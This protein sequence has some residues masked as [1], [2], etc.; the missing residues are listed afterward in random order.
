M[1]SQPTPKKGHPDRTFIGGW[2][3][4]SLAKTI[5]EIAAAEELDRSKLIRLAVRK[6]A[7]RRGVKPPQSASA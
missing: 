3:P 7:E 5:D 2:F 6:Y 4:K 1:E